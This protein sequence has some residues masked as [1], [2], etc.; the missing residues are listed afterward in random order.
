M[1]GWLD[2]PSHRENILN[3]AFAQIGLGVVAAMPSDK[4]AGATLT[5][6]FG[7]TGAAARRAQTR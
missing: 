3:P 1:R 4:P 5:Q 2:S 6:I 7:V